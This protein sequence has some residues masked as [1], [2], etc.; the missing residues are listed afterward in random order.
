MVPK[1]HT[2]KSL[3]LIISIMS[4]IYEINSLLILP[5]MCSNIT[6]K[7][8]PELW[9]YFFLSPYKVRI[10]CISGSY[11]NPSCSPVSELHQITGNSSL[12]GYIVGISRS[13]S[14]WE[15][16]KNA[17]QKLL[18]CQRVLQSGNQSNSLL[19]PFYLNGYPDLSGIKKNILFYN[20]CF[21]T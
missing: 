5:F 17:V 2:H 9:D 15:K 20:H 14:L 1:Y 10:P 13:H 8:Y 21:S 3:L 19:N 6:P 18:P 4:P 12:M 7:S 16:K 11:L